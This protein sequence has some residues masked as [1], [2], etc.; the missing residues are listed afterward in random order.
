MTLQE[1]TGSDIYGP[2]H[3]TRTTDLGKTWSDPEP[4]PAFGRSRLEDGLE[5]GVCDV[6][7]QFH[8]ASGVVLALGHNVY[9]RAGRLANPQEERFPVYAVQTADG[10]WSG[11]KR[12]RWA[13]PRGSSIYTC[14]CGERV[15]MADGSVW[16]GFSF[17]PKG[18]AA[19]SV[20]SFRCA[21]DGRELAVKQVGNELV[22]PAGRGLLEPSL[23]RWGGEYF[24]TIRAEDN[25]GYVARSGDGLQWAKPQPWTFDDGE[26]LVMSS[27]QQHWLPHSDR[28]HL[29]YT[30]RT[31]DNEKIFRWRA[32]LFIAA[33][34]PESLRL[35]RATERVVFPLDSPDPAQ[36]A[37][38]GNFH[39]LAVT[40]MESW[41]TTGEERPADA[42]GGWKGDLRL[43]RIR[44]SRPNVSV[45]QAP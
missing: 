20:T 12:L 11:R 40:P 42:A 43:A 9:Y 26:P 36:A 16:A 19:R 4:I 17:A 38:L 44:W 1:I 18:R 28:L 31:R 6:V 35:I 23:A 39:P 21:F 34:G 22:N 8:S 13:D 2:V 32:P 33:V 7:P 30:R 41:V 10:R 14:G 45:K 27:T 3:W 5:E 25:C 15:L 24:L 37:R 29:V